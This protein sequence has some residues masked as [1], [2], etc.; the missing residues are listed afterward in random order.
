MQQITFFL[1]ILS[2]LRWKTFTWLV[3]SH[4]YSIEKHSFTL[5]L[6][7]TFERSYSASIPSFG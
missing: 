1:Q 5:I 3:L 6:F 4:P 7:C 2:N